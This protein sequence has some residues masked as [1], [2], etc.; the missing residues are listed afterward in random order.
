MYLHQIQQ[1]HFQIHLRLHELLLD[2]VAVQHQLERIAAPGK[3]NRGA[4]CPRS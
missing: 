3:R 4:K 1:K 2:L